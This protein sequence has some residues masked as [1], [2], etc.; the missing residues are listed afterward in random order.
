MDQNKLFTKQLEILCQLQF[1]ISQTYICCFK[2]QTFKITNTCPSTVEQVEYRPVVEEISCL[3]C[4]YDD[5]VPP[6][7]QS[8][9]ICS[10]SPTLACGLQ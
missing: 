2:Y 8:F 3:L 4:M 10:I 7:L 6:Q 5:S 9:Y 1:N